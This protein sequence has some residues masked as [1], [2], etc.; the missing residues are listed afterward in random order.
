MPITLSNATTPLHPFPITHHSTPQS[1]TPTKSTTNRL[2]GDYN[3]AGKVYSE[4]C[5]KYSHPPS[6]FNLGRLYRASYC[7]AFL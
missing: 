1:P 4:N 6:C 3:K 2:Q 5:A 7:C